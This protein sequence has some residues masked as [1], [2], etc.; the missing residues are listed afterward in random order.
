MN[1]IEMLLEG[2]LDREGGYSNNPADRGGPT[3]FGITEQV[4]RAYGYQGDMRALPRDTAKA[5]YRKRY[6]A[7]PRF[8]DVSLRYPALAAELFDTGVNMGPKRAAEFLQ[9]ALNVLN[10]QHTDYPDINVDGDLGDMSL[11]ALDGYRTKRGSDGENVLLHMVDAFQ[12]VRYVEI[13]EANPSQETFEYGWI[14]S[15]V[16]Q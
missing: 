15:R 13:A 14:R 10:R 2:L 12:A 16:G 1:A 5:I 7:A 6:W 9:R 3:N 8:Y 11:A 4:A